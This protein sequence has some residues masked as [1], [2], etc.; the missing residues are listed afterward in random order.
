MRGGR[1]RREEG[2]VGERRGGKR[3]E[4]GKRKRERN[5]ERGEWKEREGKWRKTILHMRVRVVESIFHLSEHFAELAS[6]LYKSLLFFE[7]INHQAK[8]K[9]F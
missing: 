3:K 4:R 2:G 9:N 7:A 1:G 6:V 8:D 5:V